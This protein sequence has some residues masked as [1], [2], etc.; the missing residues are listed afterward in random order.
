MCGITGFVYADPSR[1]AEPQRLWSMCEEL[2]HRGPDERGAYTHANTG[3]GMQRLAIIDLT[4]GSQPLFSMD[5]KAWVVLNG[6][7]YN[8]PEL[9]KELEQADFHFRSHTDTEV[10]VHAYDHWGDEFIS[11][12]NG[13]FAFALWDDR[14]KRLILARDRMGKKPLYYWIDEDKIVF[15]SELKSLLAGFD[16]PR[17]INRRSLHNYLSLNYVPGPET[18]LEGFRALEP[19]HSLVWEQSGQK[20]SNRSYWDVQYEHRR[21][22]SESEKELVEELRPLLKNAVKRRLISDVP[23]GAFLSGGIDSATVV[24][25]MAMLKGGGDPVKTFTIGFGEKAKSYD[26]TEPARFAAERYGCDHT[27]FVL[28][29]REA[30]ESFLPK[31]VWHCDNLMCDPASFPL[32]LL[33][34]EARRHVTVVLTG[35]GGDEIFLGYETFLANEYARLYRRLPGFVRE[36]IIEPAVSTLPVSTKKMSFEFKA[37][38]F[39]RAAHLD[40]HEAHVSWRQIFSEEEKRALYSRETNLSNPIYRPTLETFAP[41]FAAARGLN[42]I[43]G[44]QYLDLKSFLPDD[45]LMKADSMT[46]AHSLEARCPLL[47]YSLVEFMAGIP[48]EIKFKG[49]RLKRLLKEAVSEWVPEEILTRKKAGFN[50]PMSDWFKGP[51]KGW[52]LDSLSEERIRRQG[53]LH[54]PSVTRF[55]EEHLSGRRDHGYSLWNLLCLSEWQ[56]T[57]L[58]SSSSQKS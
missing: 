12:L 20:I 51:L 41:L 26:E 6:E 42:R 52:L 40:Y 15:G 53:L 44:A 54:P 48:A 28:D 9:R 38:R 35:D 56:D 25:A 19:G 50:I 32:F 1:A 5:R 17:V 14:A 2:T 7:I 31:F 39:V 13:M 10:I 36:K 55:V 37:K 18:I 47:D 27:E 23:L 21:G 33:A 11:H 58:K 49:W 8:F 24:G 45:I 29:P 34:K 3:L 22:R 43:D 46:M 4:G 57:F 30:F 16:L